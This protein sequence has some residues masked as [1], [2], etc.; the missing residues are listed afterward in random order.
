MTSCPTPRWLESPFIIV[1][2]PTHTHT[3]S[4]IAIPIPLTYGK[5]LSFTM[6]SDTTAWREDAEY[7]SGGG[8]NITFLDFFPAWFKLFP[9]RNSQFGRP[10]NIFSGFLKVTSK[11][12]PF[13]VCFP[14][15]FSFSSFPFPFF[16]IFFYIFNF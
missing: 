14:L 13:V 10:Q 6:D 11:N 7:F 3:R 5:I 15:H 4:Q 1:S 2:V 8:G 9:G 16:L 12:K